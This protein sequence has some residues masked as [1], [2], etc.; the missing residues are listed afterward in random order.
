MRRHLKGSLVWREKYLYSKVG[1]KIQSQK[2]IFYYLHF[3]QKLRQ[4]LSYEFFQVDPL[5]LVDKNS[6]FNKDGPPSAE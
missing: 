5:L 2:I 4:I 6:D 3:L 1:T